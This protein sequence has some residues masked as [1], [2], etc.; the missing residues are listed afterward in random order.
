MRIV[1]IDRILHS[2]TLPHSPLPVLHL[3]FCLSCRAFVEFCFCCCRLQI[4][5]SAAAFCVC[6]LRPLYF[7]PFL[8]PE[9]LHTLFRSAAQQKHKNPNIL[10]SFFTRTAARK[11][12]RVDQTTA[13]T[14]SPKDNKTLCRLHV[15]SYQNKEKLVLYCPNT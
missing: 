3:A 1:V 7:S 2:L 9:A 4:Q 13:H 11:R 15:C 10:R 8:C 12:R 5:S 14:Y 6:R